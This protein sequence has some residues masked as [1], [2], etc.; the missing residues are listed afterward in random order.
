MSYDKEYQS[1]QMGSSDFWERAADQIHWDKKWTDVS[2]IQA[3]GTA[4]WLP[5]GSLNTCFNALDRHVLAGHGSRTALIYDSAYTGDINS[6]T[7][8]E[9][10][11]HVAQLAGALSQFGIA[12]GDRVIIYMPMVPEAVMAM[13]ACARIGVVHSVVFGGFCRK[14]AGDAY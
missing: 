2:L 7:Y 10:R 14:G 13:L 8:E 11:D 5:G 4:R 12:K 3:D 9:L 6:Y 1:W